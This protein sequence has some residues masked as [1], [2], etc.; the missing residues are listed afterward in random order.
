MNIKWQEFLIFYTSLNEERRK[1]D[2]KFEQLTG[3]GEELENPDLP[4]VD[5]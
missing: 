2:D 5:R 3:I 1:Y 4:L